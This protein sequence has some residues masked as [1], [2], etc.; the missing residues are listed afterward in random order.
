MHS[1]F[2]RSR[3]SLFDEEEAGNPSTSN[4]LFQDDFAA[5]GGGNNSSG[6]GAGSSPW[7][8]PTPRKQQ[9]RADLLRTLLPAADAPDSYIETFDSVVREDGTA[10][11]VAPG[12]L[13]RVLAAARLDA[14]AQAKIMSIIAPAGG[15]SGGEVVLGRNEFNVFLGLIGLAQE[16]E[17]ISLDG[18]DER[19][20]SKFICLSFSNLPNPPIFPF[21]PRTGPASTA[22]VLTYVRTTSLRP[23]DPST[24][25]CLFQKHMQPPVPRPQLGPLS[26]SLSATARRRLVDAVVS[27]RT[28]GDW[29]RD[30]LPHRGPKAPVGRVD[31]PAVL[32][33]AVSLL[34]PICL[35][36]RIWLHTNYNIWSSIFNHLRSRCPCMH[37]SNHVGFF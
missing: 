5:G 7:D 15:G 34:L 3:Q 28:I 8:M 32:C 11:K 27:W 31:R 6:G 1:S 26:T 19:R 30:V 21:S 4:S 33:C 10:G 16:G 22:Y 2:A 23:H 29:P 36:T 13:M 20:R 25:L 17:T 14:D 12:G 35:L 18:I 24:T 37:L 9:S